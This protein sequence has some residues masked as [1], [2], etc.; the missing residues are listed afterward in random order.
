VLRVD[1]RTHEQKAAADELVDEEAA[2]APF[3]GTWRVHGLT[4]EV[5]ADLTGTLTWNAGPCHFNLDTNEPL[6]TGNAIVTF[7]MQTASLS[8]T[9]DSV[10]YTD[11]NERMVSDYEEASD[12]LMAGH[13]LSLEQV[14]AAVLQVTYD[15]PLQYGNSYLCGPA[16]SRDWKLECNI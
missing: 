5:R 4:L 10:V 1:E 13:G 11:P 3:V 2:Y 7:A 12:G 9:L 8:G 6:C 14:D 16:A 15:P